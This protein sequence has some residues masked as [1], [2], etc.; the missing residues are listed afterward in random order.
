[1]MAR[2]TGSLEEAAKNNEHHDKDSIAVF[3]ENFVFAFDEFINE[4]YEGKLPIIR[5]FFNQQDERGKGFAYRLLE[6]I[7]SQEKLDIA[8]LAYYLSR[9]EDL[10]HESKKQRFREFKQEF[11]SWANGGAEVRKQAELALMLYIYEIRKD[12]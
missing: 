7:R 5:Y 10:V 9:M 6:L 11:F 1:M 12:K 8:R 3:D 2:L 4:V